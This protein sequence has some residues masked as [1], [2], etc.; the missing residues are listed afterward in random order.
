MSNAPT[1]ASR[2][3]A[4]AALTA[5]TLAGCAGHGKYTTAHKAQS[6]EKM[7]QMRSGTEWDM[8]RQAFLAGDLEK[9]LKRVDNSIALNG[10]VPKAYVL[11]GR[12]LLEMG[13]LDGARESLLKAEAL[14]PKSVDAQYYL[15]LSYERCADTETALARYTK[16]CGLDPAN[17]QFAVAAAEMMI[18]LGLLN[19]AETFLNTRKDSFQHYAGVRQTLGHVAMIRGDAT[20]AAKLFGEA[21]LL[22]P[23]DKGIV[24]DLVR[25]QMA[26][27]KFAEAEFNIGQLLKDNASSTR[28]DLRRMQAQCLM[29]LDR[30]V[31]ARELLLQLT[32]GDAGNTDVRSW[33]DLGN[34]AYT[35]KDFNRLKVTGSR[36]ITLAPNRS[37]GYMFRALWQR[38]QGEYDA[39][40]GSID[41]AVERRGTDA[42]PL[43]FR[44]ML[45]EDM[46]RRDEARKTLADALTENP[47]DK[48][49]QNLLNS[50][51]SLGTLSSAPEN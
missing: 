37:E 11:K 20:A 42:S 10:D 27:G 34:V 2:L 50:L 47:S 36:L 12:V 3:A 5:A 9:A 31:E 29:Q 26:T 35:L 7:N 51:R 40:M 21:R 41:K 33:I 45:Q 1:T 14:D 22:A 16:A 39:A 44:A 49:V 6:T 43:V 8:A 17:P 32:A 24:E 4:A 30:P 25:A 48:T 19:E 28:R 15:G 13:D 38:K 46:G 18:D 23:D